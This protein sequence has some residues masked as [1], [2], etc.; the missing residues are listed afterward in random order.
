MG[1]VFS[2]MTMSLDGYIAQPDDQIGEL[3]DWYEA[4]DVTV[5][6][7]NEDVEFT[8]DDASAGALRELLEQTGALI[9]GRRLFDIADGWNDQ[10]PVGAPVV[11]VTHHP[12]ANAAEK[13]PTTTFVAGVEEAV[14]RAKQIAGDKNVSIASANVAQ[15]ALALGLVDEVCVSLVPVL[16]GDGIPYFSTLEGGHLLLDDPVV[17]QGRRA[18]HLRYPV[19]RGDDADRDALSVKERAGSS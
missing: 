3:F 19:L 16:F 5:P 14:V 15:Q 11:V 2:H 17:V 6:N 1:K 13:W 12:P 8:V 9:S 7:P 18:L 4:G 10:H